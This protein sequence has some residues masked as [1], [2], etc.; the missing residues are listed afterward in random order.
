MYER[1]SKNE[2]RTRVAL[3]AKNPLFA[4]GRTLTTEEFKYALKSWRQTLA[5]AQ[6]PVA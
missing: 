5:F 1:A 6:V 4:E 2:R 3:H